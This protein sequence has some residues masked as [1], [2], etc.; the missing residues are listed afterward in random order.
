MSL[1]SLLLS[2]FLLGALA[3]NE[4]LKIDRECIV[5]RSMFQKDHH[6]EENL[7]VEQADSEI[8]YLKGKYLLMITHLYQ[9]PVAFEDLDTLAD[10]YNICIYYLSEHGKKPRGK[11]PRG[12]VIPPY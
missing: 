3:T 12:Y 6:F 7:S 8:N 9:D 1:L 2:L 11:I 4:D 10:T 5:S